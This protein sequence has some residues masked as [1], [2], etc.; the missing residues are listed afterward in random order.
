MG[1]RT[2]ID[3]ASAATWSRG[4]G[5]L[6]LILVVPG[7]FRSGF[8]PKESCG[9]EGVERPC[10]S[11]PVGTEDVGECHGGTQRC[12][13]GRWSDC[14]GEWV[15]VPEACDGRDD[16]CNDRVDDVVDTM[17]YTGPA[18][19]AGVGEC[20]SGTRV[21]IDGTW[22]ECEGEVTPR[23]LCADADCGDRMCGVECNPCPEGRACGPTGECVIDREARVLVPA[24]TFLMGTDSFR[25]SRPVH[26]VTISRPFL[27]D[28]FEVS[29]GRFRAC[30]EADLC[31]ETIGSGAECNYPN[32]RWDLP[33]N[34]IPWVWAQRFCE[35]YGGR[36]P[37]E[38][39]W[40]YAARG[41]DERIYPW[42][43]DEPTCERA[44]Y[45]DCEPNYDFFIPST[46]GSHPAGASHF[47][48]EDLAGNVWEWVADWFSADAYSACA[49]GCTD[50]LGPS[51]PPEN[52]E[53]SVRGGG[54]FASDT[55]DPMV[56][57][58]SALRSD[59]RDSA[60]P[61]GSFVDIGFR[62]IYPV[63]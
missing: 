1:V 56:Y 10:Y 6:L 17:C 42:G 57:P 19:S 36:L 63:E 34:C 58:L 48:V 50:P 32:E 8:S 52:T 47:G 62:C 39:E 30:V 22:T 49:D 20:H 25:S 15:P 27:I 40:E 21:C 13:D 51:G 3:N 43:N 26:E 16:D 41:T 55:R 12:V 38:A 33:L 54:Q 14:E 59:A 46:I 61:T 4:W 31:R 18:G 45:F 11:G 29:A 23:M 5:A 9:V 60:S 2:G 7:C 24:G 37:T 53:R 44:W 35:R 28:R